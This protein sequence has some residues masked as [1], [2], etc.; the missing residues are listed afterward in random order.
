[1]RRKQWGWPI[2]GWR[3]STLAGGRQ[4]IANEHENVQLVFNGEIYNHIELRAEL[5]SRGIIFGR[6]AM[7]KSL[8]ISMKQFGLELFSHLNGMFAFALWDNDKESLVLAR[9]R[10]GQKPLYY[11]AQGAESVRS[12]RKL[13]RLQPLLDRPLQLN[14]SAIDDFLAFK[15]MPHATN[16]C[17]RRRQLAPGHYLTW[18]QGPVETSPYWTYPEPRGEYRRQF[19]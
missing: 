2:L 17:S 12:L 4:P 11:S 8:S 16:V 10:L 3:L 6:I 18:S 5:E 15:Y 19:R 14:L 7:P 13:K 9:D 1:M